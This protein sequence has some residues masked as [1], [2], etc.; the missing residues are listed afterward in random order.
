MTELFGLP[1]TTLIWVFGVGL[2][3]IVAWSLLLALRQP[4][5][6]RLAARNIPRRWGRSLL[7]VLG[8]TLATTII[9]SA[10]ATGDT[11]ALSARG[12]VL[13][14]LGDIDEVISS[15]EESDVEITGESINL[16]YFDAAAFDRIRAAVIDLPEVDGVMPAILE[17]VGAQ[18]LTSRQTEPRLSVI[19]VDVRYMAGFGTIRNRQGEVIDLATLAAGEVLLNRD[20]ADELQAA[21]GD[22]IVIYASVGQQAARV[23]DVI[24]YDGMATPDAGLLMALAEVQTLFG[25]EGLIKHV[26]VSNSGD[27]VGGVVHTDAV[28][29]A[30]QPTLDDLGLAIEPTKREDL[31]GADEAGV[32][33]SSIFITFGSFSIMAGVML[34]FLL[35]VMLAGERKSEMGIARAVGTERV[36]L[37]EMFMFEGMLYD[38]V[39]AAIGALA[40]IG[41]AR[42]MILALS[43]LLEDFGVD[44]R[45]T[46]SA[47]S[48]VVAYSMGVVLTFIV[49]T[50]SAWRVSLLNIVTA[51]RNLPEPL[52]TGR[53]RASLVW[54]GVFIV[55]G[56]LFYYLGASSEQATP[57]YVG[58]T[59]IIIAFVPLL[60]W[61]GAPDRLAFSLAGGLIVVFWLLPWNITEGMFGQLKMDFNIWIVGGLITVIGVSWLVIYNSDLVVT[62][63]LSTLGRVRGLAPILKTALTYPLTNRF[64]TGVTM[65]MFTLVV[66]TLV[67]G[68]TVT[69]AFTEAFDDVELFGGGYHIRASTV[70]VSPIDD[71]DAAISASPGLDR[72]DFGVIST[73]SL[74]AIEARQTDGSLVFGDYPLRGF[75]DSFFDHTAYGMAAIGD[76]YA[77]A[78]AVWQALKADPTLAVVDGLVAPRR[79]QFGFGAPVPDFRLEGFFLEDGHFSPVR[80]EVRDP[81]TLETRELTVIG[82][83]QDVIPEYMIGVTTSQRF[84]DTAFPAYAAP[85]AHLIEVPEGAAIEPLA[86]ALESAFLVNGMEAV[87]VQDEL[88]ELVAANRTFNYLIQGFIGLGLVVGVAALGVVSARTVVERRQEIGVMRAIGFEQGRVQL[89]FL[90][91]S[92]MVAV[93]GLTIGTL[94]GLVLS[95][96]IIDDSRSQASWQNIQF[97]VPWLNIAIIYAVVLVAALLTAFLPARQAS[98]VYPAQALRYE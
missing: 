41:V 22:E 93:A 89:S 95:Y 29:A 18:N 92:S 80:I 78:S 31:E 90:I 61:A 25:K 71:L 13:R 91:E 30:L 43:S 65:A 9:A 85:A 63:T 36:H 4:V 77:S 64:R 40:G 52:T 42:L 38:V 24:V 69:T 73:Q 51:I 20:A 28:I 81:L 3:L 49:V 6:F 88:D 21:P 19:G 60:R 7:I 54:G 44:V 55:L 79:D 23:R 86:A 62:A 34:I 39:A 1:M 47:R 50:F 76:G 14:A 33:F 96:N 70:Q 32:L 67:V 66:F 84:V 68:G 98:R 97:A 37:V 26:V 5:L 16:E 48:L 74:V 15:T 56:A 53:G 46:V 10:L 94:L 75:S 11:V 8:L 59:L 45:F 27:S 35:F 2:A 58:V 82:I 87:Q 83:L 72:G 17:E 57:L 12:E